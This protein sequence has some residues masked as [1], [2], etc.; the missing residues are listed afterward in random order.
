M[1]WLEAY[2]TYLPTY[3]AEY[4]LVM[5]EVTML[6]HLKDTDRTR[7]FRSIR[8]RVELGSGDYNQEGQLILEGSNALRKW[9]HAIGFSNV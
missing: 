7:V 8:A 1:E 5:A 3:I 6:P 4:Q 2:S 9:F